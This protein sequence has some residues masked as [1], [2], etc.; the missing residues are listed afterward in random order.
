MFRMYLKS[1]VQSRIFINLFSLQ[2]SSWPQ[3]TGLTF[4]EKPRFIHED[5]TYFCLIRDNANFQEVC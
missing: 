4:G 5:P 2:P 1:L 3:K